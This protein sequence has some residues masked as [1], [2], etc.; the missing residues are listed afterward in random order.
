MN[1]VRSNARRETETN[2]RLKGRV[3]SRCARAVKGMHSNGRYGSR[4]HALG[5][6]RA[7]SSLVDPV[8]RKKGSLVLST[9]DLFF[10]YV[11]YTYYN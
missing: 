1:T 8:E 3:V 5:S 6:T 10:I 7:S 9:K 4:V 11:I 2:S